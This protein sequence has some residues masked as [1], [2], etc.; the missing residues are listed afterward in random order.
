MVPR[1]L[2]EGI[3]PKNRLPNKVEVYAIL[4]RSCFNI[5]ICRYS[6]SQIAFLS[7]LCGFVV[8]LVFSLWICRHCL[9]TAGSLQTAALL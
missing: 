6:C 7:L 1:G 4:I 2:Q 3:V 5:L 8:F 9:A